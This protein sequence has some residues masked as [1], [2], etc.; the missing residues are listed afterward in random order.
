MVMFDFNVKIGA[1]SGEEARRK[2]KAAL[3]LVKRLSTDELE[4]LADVVSNQP[5]KVKIAKKFLGL[6]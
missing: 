5:G 6:K 4:K 2:M 3:E 1:A